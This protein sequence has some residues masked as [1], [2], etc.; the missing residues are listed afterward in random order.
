MHPKDAHIMRGM[1]TD[2]RRRAET[3]DDRSARLRLAAM[4]AYCDKMAAAIEALVNKR[5]A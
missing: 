5:K 2:Y 1:A 4:A 3:D